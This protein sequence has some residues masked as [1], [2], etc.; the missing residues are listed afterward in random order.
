MNEKETAE[1]AERFDLASQ[2]PTT[3]R[4]EGLRALLPEAF[5]GDKVDFDAL[6]RSLGDW[7]D[8]GPER[9]GLTWP[10]KAECIRVVQEASI[11]TL[12][13]MSDE[14]VDWDATKNVIIEGEN[15]EALKLLQKAYYGK[16]KMIY[17]DPPY[18]T[19]K[20]FIYPDNFSEG[21]G[22]YLRY[23]GQVDEEGIRLS[24]NSETAGRYHSKWL[25]MM[26]PRLF[27]SRNLLARDGFIFVS[28]GDHEVQHLR[29]VLNE[30]YGEEN[31]V[32]CMVWQG[33]RR[34]DSKLVSS[35]HD[36]ILIYARDLPMITGQDLHWEE[37]KEGLDEIYEFADTVQAA[38]A[39]D[40]D[41]AHKRLL[42]WFKDL[43]NGHASAEHSHYTYL[44]RRGLH[45]R[46]NISSPNYRENLIYDFLGYSPP[47]NGWRYER[48][49]MERL[50]AED[51]LHLPE[52]KS[53]RIA[54]KRY[55]R[56]TETW[57]PN[58]VFYRDR[59]GARKVVEDLLGVSAKGL[60]DFPKDHGV[61]GRLIATVTSGEDL[62]VDFFAGSGSTA[63]AV[64]AEN[65][66]DGAR[67]RFL[68]V[69]LP[70]EVDSAEYP[71][72]SAITRA[73]VRN[74]GAEIGASTPRLD[75]QPTDTGF[76]SFSL[77][78]SNFAVWSGAGD[79][80][81]EVAQQLDLAVDHVRDGATEASIVT[82]L[83]L[84]AGF[85]LT[86]EV[87]EADFA[88]EVAYSVAAG[89]LLIYVGDTL[90]LQAVEA[91]AEADPSLILILDS[92]FGA[93]DELKVNAMQT[94]RSRNQGAG[95]DIALKVV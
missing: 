46:D 75:E 4:I 69:Q 14:S 30:L 86:A 71:T 64:M 6:R 39:D 61:L 10:G 53:R 22:D 70:E 65:A 31:F 2:P 62:V 87:E 51:R 73:R 52:D 66:D 76:R 40:F 15:L 29:L 91:M 48:S 74:A 94:V 77:S 45:Y 26:Y 19:G 20:E 33:G 93:D 57:A 27:L 68:L 43:P 13:P 35:G 21:L 42:Q 92:S 63:H 12:V 25:S 72:I 80:A 78:S 59:R 34:N 7:I 58:S 28:I 89:E 8:P 60:F 9:F 83:L 54:V 18:N 84:K 88:G 79:G 67:R 49:T 50:Q 1:T 44:D 5:T 17:I 90:T 82:E 55:L 85:E 47:P 16:V 41:E 24:A 38:V 95:S 23:S 11:G 36:Y 32:A 37:R 3:D 56:E 81:E